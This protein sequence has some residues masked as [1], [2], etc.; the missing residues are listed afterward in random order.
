MIMPINTYRIQWSN[1]Q[2]QCRPT[3]NCT[4]PPSPHLPTR[5][6]SRSNTPPPHLPTRSNS[7]SNRHTRWDPAPGE[8]CYLFIHSEIG[9][10]VSVQIISHWVSEASI[11]S[12][13]FYLVSFYQ[14]VAFVYLIQTV[15]G[16]VVL[17]TFSVRCTILFMD[18]SANGK[19]AI[20][21]NQKLDLL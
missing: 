13:Q 1:K 11:N 21:Q 9:L 3:G 10:R 16:T 6:N 14:S 4:P 18:R 19:L 5:S 20:I 7:R 2:G 15:T 8:S 17:L 12:T